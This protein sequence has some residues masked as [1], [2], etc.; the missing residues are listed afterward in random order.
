MS[1]KR[2]H[3]RD[4]VIVENLDID[5]E[6]GFSAL[7]GE[8]G[9]GKSILIDA[10]Q[11]VLGN[12]ADAGWVRES[13]NKAEVCAEFS[14][15]L[16][17]Q[18]WLSAWL[19]E[20]GF[21]ENGTEKHNDIEAKSSHPTLSL[22]R[23]IDTQGKSRAWVN[24]GVATAGQLK[25]LGG[26][27]VDIHGQHAW[28]T[29]G[30]P[31][32]MRTL[33][34]AYADG[35]I[36]TPNTAVPLDN[37]P[38]QGHQNNLVL[39]SEQWHAWQLAQRNR[40]K[41]Q[42]NAGDL[43]SQKERLEWQIAELNK[44]QFRT[45]TR[46]LHHAD[47]QSE[48]DALNAEHTKL[49]HSQDLLNIANQVMGHLEGRDATHADEST[50]IKSKT[51]NSSDNPQEKW[52]AGVIVPLT[53]AIQALQ[54]R[55]AIEP[56]FNNWVDALASAL[57]Q[58]EDNLHAVH[59]Y[60]RRTD[61]EPERLATLDERLS[62]WLSLARRFKH[63]APELPDLWLQWQADLIA[64]SQHEDIDELV[65]KEQ[66]AQLSYIKTAKK[67]SLQRHQSA[68]AL[69]ATITQAMQGL[70][71]KGGIFEVAFTP[72]APDEY[73]EHGT[74]NV[75]FLVSGHAGSTPRPIGKVASGGEL[76]RVALAI[77]V[78]TSR[79]G[80]APTLIFDEVDSGIGGTV[81]HTVGQLMR[82]LGSDKQVLAVT[83]LAQVAACGH[84]H[85]KVIKTVHTNSAGKNSTRSNMIALQNQDRTAEIARMLGSEEDS[86]VGVAHAL[87]MLHNAKDSPTHLS[88]L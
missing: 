22:K 43:D 32:A 56:Q 41:S 66:K 36:D 3:L 61:L 64:L 50:N 81:A 39:L 20:A 67:V 16:H 65:R 24:G 23:T 58:I 48:W 11:L 13:C 57:A 31:D 40:Q 80:Q 9:A 25:I 12:R 42:Q 86:E 63:T 33:L 78:A 47:V 14:V 87:E 51:N 30:K 74:E 1:L 38:P 55:T 83:H 44:L 5:I 49:T 52:H 35:T 17:L 77:S 69:S 79:L 10:L 18:A 76:S 60:L 2:I 53:K 59:A 6:P 28:A 45:T 7:T 4:F 8:T 46:T 62:L 54:Q 75:V 72:L 70:G 26:K 73:R 88:V 84:Q 82:Q 29:L 37:Q 71:M 21:D 19:R 68:I 85:F 34:D 15:P 27:L